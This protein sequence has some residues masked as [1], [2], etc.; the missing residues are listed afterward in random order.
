MLD[1]SKFKA[2][3]DDKVNVN[4]NVKF[5]VGRVENIVGKGEK[6]DDKVNANENVKFGLGRVENIVGKGENAG[7]QHF[8]LFPQCFQK[9]SFSRSLKLWIVWLKKKKELKY[10]T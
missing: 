1:W 3:A 5:G 10:N 2:F 7:Y 9:P 4:E 8:L 6:A